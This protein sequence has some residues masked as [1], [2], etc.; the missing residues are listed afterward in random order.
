MQ[1]P[2]SELVLV[3]HRLTRVDVCY[4][5]QV[6]E[7]ALSHVDVSWKNI[8]HPI[9]AFFLENPEMAAGYVIHAGDNFNGHWWTLRKVSGLWWDLN[10]HLPA[11]HLLEGNFIETLHMRED[12]TVFVIP[13]KIPKRPEGIQR[14]PSYAHMWTPAQVLELDKPSVRRLNV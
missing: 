8:N 10:S 5:M 14:M 13:S 6:L 1:I 2:H 11:P 9:M 4:G 12:C 3:A 7:C